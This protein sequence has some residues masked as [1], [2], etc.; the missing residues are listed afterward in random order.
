MNPDLQRRIQRY[1]WDR[2]APH[3]E[4]GW[5]EQLWPAQESLL[6]E[7][8]PQSGETV[9]DISCG[10]GLVTI[11]VAQI[12]QPGGLVTGID[13]S[14]GMIEEAKSRAAEH[15][16]DNVTYLRMDAEVI[17]F[18]DNTFDLVICSLGLMYFPNPDKALEEIYRVL[19][20]GG[21]AAA[22]VWGARKECGWA[23]IFPITDR[24]VQ[25]EVCPLFFQLGTGTSLSK[26]FEEAGF[27]KL[28]SKRFSYDLYFRNDEQACTAAFQ[29]GL[30]PS[31][32]KNLMI[33]PKKRLA[34][35]TWILSSST[36][37]GRAMISQENL[38]LQKDLSKRSSYR[39]PFCYSLVLKYSHLS[40]SARKDFC[41]R[42]V[43]KKNFH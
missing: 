18:P 42:G 33:R 1:G 11:P 37:M 14:E 24:R 26:A 2:A 31:R 25:S 38:S 34:R 27:E 16:I 9:L 3:Y 19:N 23:E 41:F 7:I 5:Q 20:P 29:G 10:T 36:E 30:W 40:I 4:T 28:K 32:I 43:T 22:L 6:S 21:R 13:L 15:G 35:N 17:D 12:V 39:K 8:E